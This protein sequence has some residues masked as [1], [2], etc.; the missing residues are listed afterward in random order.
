MI[1]S[2]YCFFRNF[3]I[4]LDPLNETGSF[5]EFRSFFSALFQCSVRNCVYVWKVKLVGVRFPLGQITSYWLV[6][7]FVIFTLVFIAFLM[8]PTRFFPLLFTTSQ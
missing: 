2:I 5:T 6:L 8:E 7:A 4:L 1:L 3:R